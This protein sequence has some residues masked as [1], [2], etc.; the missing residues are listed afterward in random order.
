[1]SYDSITIVGAMAEARIGYHY[2]DQ[3]NMIN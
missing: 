2:D 1:M 3:L